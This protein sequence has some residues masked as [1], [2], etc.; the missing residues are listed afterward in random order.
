MSKF[1]LAP[2]EEKALLEIIERCLPQLETETVHAENRDFH[3]F[4]KDREVFMRELIN[5]LKS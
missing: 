4:L 3:K 2:E 1:Y 5:R